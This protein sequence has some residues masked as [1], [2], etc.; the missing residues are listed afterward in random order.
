MFSRL[1]ARNALLA[2]FYQP[3]SEIHSG[4]VKSGEA[5]D[6][7]KANLERKYGD[8][9]RVPCVRSQIDQ[10]LL[11]VLANAAQAIEGAGRIAI[12]TRIENGWAVV[13][14]SRAAT[15]LIL[16]IDPIRQ[17]SPTF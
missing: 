17:S 11:N 6:F 13:A 14:I 12:E 7:L 8:L 1:P 3:V 9:S 16:N 15:I 5:Y 2:Q 10:V 4:P